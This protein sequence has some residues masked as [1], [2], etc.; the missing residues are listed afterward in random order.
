MWGKNLTDQDVVGGV[1]GFAADVLGTA[2]TSLSAPR[3]VGVEAR[4]NF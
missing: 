3:T 4:Y 1:G 2:I